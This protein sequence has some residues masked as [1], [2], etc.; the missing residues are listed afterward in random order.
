MQVEEKPPSEILH[1]NTSK[2]QDMAIPIANF[3]TP[4][5]KP[6][7]DTSTKIIDKKTIQDVG[8]EIPLYH[9][10]VYRPLPKPVKHLYPILLEAY[11]TL[12]QN[13]L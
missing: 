1:L 3:T 11:W 9:D 13:W 4:Q 12:T 5:I 2:I 6:K 7:G 8:R 10:S